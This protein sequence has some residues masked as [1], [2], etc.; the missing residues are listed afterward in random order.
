MTTDFSIQFS[1]RPLKGGRVGSRI[2]SRSGSR[3][4]REWIAKRE[5]DFPSTSAPA[6][7]PRAVGPEGSPSGSPLAPSGP[8]AP[9]C[10]AP[11]PNADKRRAVEMLLSDKEWRKKSPE[12]IARSCGVSRPF[13]MKMRQEQGVTVTSSEGMDGKT[14]PA[15]RQ[16]QDGKVRRVRSGPTVAPEHSSNRRSAP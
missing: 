2:D 7:A 9:R 4:D 11:V 3:M 15:S 13:V 12:W 8:V 1:I 6:R 16:D 5:S 10:L 14:Y